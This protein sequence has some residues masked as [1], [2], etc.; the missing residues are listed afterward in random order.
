MDIAIVIGT[1]SYEGTTAGL[2]FL[3]GAPIILVLLGFVISLFTY[4][5]SRR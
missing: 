3:I 4:S 2:I 1:T 5:W